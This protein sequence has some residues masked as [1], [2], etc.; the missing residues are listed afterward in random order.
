MD[1]EKALQVMEQVIREYRQA[2]RVWKEEPPIEYHEGDSILKA[3]GRNIRMA[4]QRQHMTLKQLAK[5]ADIAENTI[6]KAERGERNI[7]IVTADKIAQ[8]LGLSLWAILVD[9]TED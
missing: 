4:R 8:G 1:N 7:S 5:R 3:V 2:T 6:Q 9:D